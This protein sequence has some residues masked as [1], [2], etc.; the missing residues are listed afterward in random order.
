MEGLHKT[1]SKLRHDI[2]NHL[3]TINSFLEKD[4]IGEAQ[5]HIAE[6]M[7]VY[8][9]RLEIVHTG[10]PA[11]DGLL[12]FKL[13]SLSDLDIKIN[14]KADLPSDFNLSP[15]DLTVI[16]GNLIDNALQAVSVVEEDKFID[17]RMKCSKGMMLIKA[18]NPYKIDVKKERGKII[19]SKSDKENHGWGLRSIEE[20]LEKY[21]GTSDINTDNN[22]FTIT[23][24]LYLN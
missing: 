14:I 21:N 22:I 7:D 5:A 19:T 8:Q 4:K 15:F 2:K 6:I 10:Y 11:V 18:T 9:N 13:R 1:T 24:A 20:I 17:L 16:L 23:I 3:I 12:N